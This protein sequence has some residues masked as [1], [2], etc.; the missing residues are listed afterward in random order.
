MIRRKRKETGS[1]PGFNTTPVLGIVF[2]LLL[3][4]VVS[5]PIAQ[6]R[7]VD[8]TD[9]YG[10]DCPGDAPVI[11]IIVDSENRIFVEESNRLKQ[12]GRRSVRTTVARRLAESPRSAIFVQAHRQSDMGTVIRVVDE[13]RMA[14][15]SPPV[16]VSI[17]AVDS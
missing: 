5:V 2:L 15:R 9:G 17:A 13:A 10:C 3:F 12:I 11:N 8:L 14:R 1:S 4:F 16:P 7:G 6:E